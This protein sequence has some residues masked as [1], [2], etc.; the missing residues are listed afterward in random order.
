MTSHFIRWRWF[1]AIAGILLF[2]LAFSSFTL[3]AQGML[4]DGSPEPNTILR[5]PPEELRLIFDQSV[6]PWGINVSLVNNTTLETIEVSDAVFRNSHELMFT[7][8]GEMEPSEYSVNYRVIGEAGIVIE[9]TYFFTYELP[10]PALV[11]NS[12]VDGQAFTEDTIPVKLRTDFFDIN[13]GDR[14]VLV[15]V[16]GS[17][18]T[19]LSEN[20][21]TITGLGTG[22][23]NIRMVLHQ[24]GEEIPETSH[25]MYISI[26]RSAPP[27]DLTMKPQ[28]RTIPLLGGIVSIFIVAAGYMLGRSRFL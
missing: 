26:A 12:P 19:D 20:T 15:F 5:D 27:A 22:V 6:R 2:S 14:G 3:L 10:R 24:N 13:Q 1:A 17:L 18:E 7:I 28:Q 25:T 16:D 21:Y 8:I 4:I 9:G 23:H 11:I